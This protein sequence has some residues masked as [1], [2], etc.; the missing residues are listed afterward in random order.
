MTTIEDSNEFE[1]K[2]IKIII[3]N[4]FSLSLISIIFFVL[5]IYISSNSA[6][7]TII[8]EFKENLN[9]KSEISRHLDSI[10][11][12]NDLIKIYSSEFK[13]NNNV[14]YDITYRNTLQNIDKIVLSKIKH[15]YKISDN[16][17]NK[18][19]F[20]KSSSDNSTD[21]LIQIN[22]NYITEYIY[23][24]NYYHKIIGSFYEFNEGKK[25]IIEIIN[26][27]KY[28]TKNAV[29]D[30]FLNNY[31]KIS[32][33]LTKQL[34]IEKNKIQRYKKIND[35]L[36]KNTKL[37]TDTLKNNSKIS[38]NKI[39]GN[40]NQA[41]FT[42]ALIDYNERIEKNNYDML[43][44]KNSIDEINFLLEYNK[45]LNVNFFD[46]LVIFNQVDETKLKVLN[47]IYDLDQIIL[48]IFISLVLASIL[49]LILSILKDFKYFMILRKI[50]N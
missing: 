17:S 8:Y 26:K 10:N 24:N 40:N 37:I 15:S 11:N 38:K 16:E 5:F 30:L 42:L 2:I 1:N 34:E 44:T 33:M 29:K 12:F 13:K 45:K 36:I 6:R 48:I 47:Q 43:L 25:F 3:S 19:S 9:D 49:V 21:G 46:T 31:N 39:E 35:Q 41:L 32:L 4:L 28:D 27:S 7:Y 22:F 18:L 20:S 14:D 23:R 50:V